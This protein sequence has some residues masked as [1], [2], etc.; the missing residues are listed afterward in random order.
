[1]K[2]LFLVVT[3]TGTAEMLAEDIIDAHGAGHDYSLQLAERTD[4]SVLQQV[5]NLVVISSTYGTGDIPDPGLPLFNTLKRNP[6]QLSHLR[7]A[8]ISL[9]DS[10]YKDTFANGGLQWNAML[11][12]SGA[13]EMLDPLLLDASGAENMSEQAV[14]WAGRWSALIDEADREGAMEEAV[15][16]HDEKA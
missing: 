11:K 6:E 4:P 9:G 14:R 12:A 10:V 15:L 1:M 13:Q 5:R 8:V 7:Y 3:M 16:C 2:T